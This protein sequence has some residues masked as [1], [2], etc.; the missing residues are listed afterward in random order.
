MQRLCLMLTCFVLW[1]L[2]ACEPLAPEVTRL[3]LVSDTDLERLDTVTFVVYAPPREGSVMRQDQTAVGS[4]KP[5]EPAWLVM[6]KSSES[7]SVTV[8]M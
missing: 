7:V 8:T 1:A 4:V 6:S 2:A 5:G 3:I